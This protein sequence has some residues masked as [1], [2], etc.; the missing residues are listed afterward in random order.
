MKHWYPILFLLATAACTGDDTTA[1]PEPVADH[2]QYFGFAITDCGTN[3]LPLVDDFV[4]L[5]DMCPVDYGNLDDRIRANAAG[6]NKVMIHL[7]GLFIDAVEDA[8]SPTGVRYELYDNYVEQFA[9]WQSA[10]ADLSSG[11]VVAFTIADEPAWNQMAMD[12]LHTIAT[13]VKQAYPGIN[14]LVVEGPESI[15]G[16]VL[17]DD[18]DWIAFDRYGTLDP[19]NDPVYQ[20]SLTLL[21]S[22]RT[23]ADQKLAI[24]MESQWL[25]YYNEEG[26][27]EVVLND[28]AKSYYALAQQ[29]EDVV[30]LISY[31]LPSSFDTPDQRGFLRAVGRRAADDSYHWRGDRW[32][33][34][35]TLRLAPG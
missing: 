31:L 8:T 35:T 23:R 13:L 21:R 10:N 12:D 2:L 16:L 1:L 19:L 33:V 15:D 7:Q 14:I 6:G 28:M 4:N 9:R 11:E 18:I 30:A 3:L 25:K 29:E 22:R 26:F 20:Q 17:S 27:D 5:V 24:I 32:A 34:K